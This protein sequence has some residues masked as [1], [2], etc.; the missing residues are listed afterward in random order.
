[1]WC[2]T[3]V[4]VGFYWTIER[5]INKSSGT[6]QRIGLGESIA[7]GVIG[8]CGAAAT[9]GTESL[10]LATYCIVL[11]LSPISQLINFGN[12]LTQFVILNPISRIV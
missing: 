7:C 5:V 2:K 8:V 3:V 1:L 12:D 9:T 4:E 11:I 6:T 10:K